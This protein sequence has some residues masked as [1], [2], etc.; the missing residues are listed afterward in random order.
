MATEP[1]KEEDAP[2]KTTKTNNKNVV[3]ST[4]KQ[5]GAD[6][7]NHDV[8]TSENEDEDEEENEFEDETEEGLMQSCYIFIH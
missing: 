7:T 8:M 1:T 6:E 4:L 5:D 2:A 3:A